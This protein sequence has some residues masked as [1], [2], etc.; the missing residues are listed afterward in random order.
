MS[1]G[2][3]LPLSDIP[4]LGGLGGQM[5]NMLQGPTAPS[6]AQPGPMLFPP[7]HTATNGNSQWDLISLGLDEPLPDQDVI[8]ELYVIPIELIWNLCGFPNLSPL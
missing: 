8:E 6:T 5:D 1:D 2:H 4:S 3:M 7:Q